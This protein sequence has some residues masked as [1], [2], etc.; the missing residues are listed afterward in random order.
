MILCSV[1]KC[2][3]CYNSPNG[4]FKHIRS[5][6]CM[7][8]K[9]DVCKKMLSVPYHINNHLK[10]H[11]GSNLYPCKHCDRQFA[12]RS[13]AKAHKK[14]HDM[15]LKCPVCPKS[16]TKRYQ[17][18]VSLNIHSRGM[19]G[20]G[21][22]APC[23]KNCKWKSMYAHHIK[24]CKICFKKLADFKLNGYDFMSYINLGHRV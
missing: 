20:E 19:H 8:Y 1:T 13:L 4:L 10:M 5:H 14:T 9:C 18:Q 12:S 21:W 23:R 7:K 24:K 6:R 16:M 17:S 2:N 3:A 22:Y 15:E 11:T